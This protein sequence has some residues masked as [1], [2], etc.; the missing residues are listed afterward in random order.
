M[1]KVGV[2]YQRKWRVELKIKWRIGKF[3]HVNLVNLIFL[4][5]SI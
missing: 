2:K 5:V 3:Y 1:E 4:R